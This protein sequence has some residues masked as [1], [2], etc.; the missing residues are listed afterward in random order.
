MAYRLDLGEPIGAELRRVATEEL[1]AAADG[2]EA[3]RA[4]TRADAVPSA[5]KSVKKTR[6]LLRLVRPGLP[7]DVFRR[8]QDAL[9]S[10]GGL[11]SGTRDADVLGRT[12]AGL[13]ERF[14]GRVAA[15]SFGGLRRAVVAQ[16]RAEGGA[17]DR[18]AEATAALR[19]I[20]ARAADW[21]LED[22]GG[23]A[24]RRGAVRVHLAGAQRFKAARK[25]GG[26]EAMHDL[27]K[28]VKDRWYHERL[29]R[30]GW[31]AV[32]GAYADEAG[33]LGDLLGDEHD[34]AVLDERLARH[35]DG[36]RTRAAL[37]EVRAM[38]AERRAELSDEA[39]ALAGRL[40]GEHPKAYGRRL[41]LGLRGARAGAA[42]DTEAAVA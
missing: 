13:A 27:R 33:R 37:G 3:A 30:D 7:A 8:E 23:K 21:P 12:V 15:S 34:L 9:R 11:L 38:I 2:L 28:R 22:V 6:A 41:A 18:S 26:G 25:A 19:A 20:A 29:L 36:L 32:A 42:R 39:L 5:R 4:R 17:E 24:L 1:D 16:A 35:G 31:P 14:A 40:L 10:A